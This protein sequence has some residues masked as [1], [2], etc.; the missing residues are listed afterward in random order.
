MEFK[1]TKGDWKIGE[2]Y[3][4]LTEIPLNTLNDNIVVVDNGGQKIER[5]ERQA[6]AKLIA[7]APE[8]L[9][10]LQDLLHLHSCEMEGISYGQ[11]TANQWM[12]AVN[13]GS[14]IINKALE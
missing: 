12:D 13:Y 11:P 9:K 10:A 3:H 5:E 14:E 1:G 8:L 4:E 6:N 7:A 2:D